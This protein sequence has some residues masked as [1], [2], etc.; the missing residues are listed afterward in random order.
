[1]TR[2]L[3]PITTIGS[4]VESGRQTGDPA[5][6][7]SVN[8]L[9]VPIS[10]VA[11]RIAPIYNMRPTAHQTNEDSGTTLGSWDVP[12]YPTHGLWRDDTE[13]ALNGASA[14]EFIGPVL[15]Q[16]GNAFSVAMI[17]HLIHP[18]APTDRSTLRGVEIDLSEEWDDLTAQATNTDTIHTP[19]EVRRLPS[20][21]PGRLL[22]SHA[23]AAL[24]ADAGMYNLT[25]RDI[26]GADMSFA[27]AVSA[28]SVQTGKTAAVTTDPDA[29]ILTDMAIG[30]VGS[31]AT[32]SRLY[33]G[34]ATVQGITSND[35]DTASIT[36]TGY[37]VIPEVNT[38]ERGYG[39]PQPLSGQMLTAAVR[40]LIHA[41]RTN[42]ATRG[43]VL[44]SHARKAST[45]HTEP[46]AA[47]WSASSSVWSIATLSA[48]FRLPSDVLPG[49][50]N[51]TSAGAGGSISTRG[52]L[53]ARVILRNAQ[54]KIGIRAV[55]IAGSYGQSSTY[56]AWT[57]ST[58]THGSASWA[59]KDLEILFPSGI[60]PGDDYEIGI[61]WKSSGATDGYLQAWSIWEPS[62]TTVAP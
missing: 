15:P 40:D 42:Y 20:G 21:D 62:L 1:M 7:G 55:T 53:N 36:S 13:A 57:I 19:V 46:T 3:N 17:G 60:A 8:A 16:F 2:P 28:V 48:Y 38:I 52:G 33:I 43:Q 44:V 51:R 56:G 39:A 61:W 18:S 45:S 12:F 47:L 5:S 34:S 27:G 37:T 11:G 22:D 59:G 49:S 26:S 14:G 4:L 30:D 25:C 10:H 58:A 31:V 35:S 50:E 29:C 24:Y 6:P 23:I 41:D 32:L 9:A 54:I